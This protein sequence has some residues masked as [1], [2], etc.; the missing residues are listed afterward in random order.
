MNVKTGF[1]LLLH[2]TGLNIKDRH[3][4]SELRLGRR[5][6]QVNGSKKQAVITILISN[7]ITFQPKLIK[8]DGEGHFILIKRKIHQDDI[9][10]L[11]TYVP[12]T[13]TPTFVK[14]TL[15]ELKSHNKTNMLL[16][17]DYNTQ[18]SP[19]NRSS[20]QKLNRKYTDLKA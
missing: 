11:N 3:F 17:G 12:N 13:R 9:S 8:S 18:L 2:T 15:L 16:V 10:I 1:I 7:K 19:L 5:F 4:I 6:F 20:K 14:E